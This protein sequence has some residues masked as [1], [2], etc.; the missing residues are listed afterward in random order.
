M[1]YL[2]VY[3]FI[4]NFLFFFIIKLHKKWFTTNLSNTKY[5][6]TNEAPLDSSIW[7]DFDYGAILFTFYANDTLGN[8]ISTEITL[9]KIKSQSFLGGTNE[10]GDDDDDSNGDDI[11]AENI[12]IITIVICSISGVAVGM[13]G[14][15]YFLKKKTKKNLNP[16]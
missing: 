15:L 12:L 7:N 2:F 4:I 8:I 10:V 1:S 6:Y 16:N 5:F 9:L 14:I 3:F 13:I 11:S